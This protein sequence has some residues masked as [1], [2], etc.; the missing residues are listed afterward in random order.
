M[1]FLL[2][3]KLNSSCCWVLVLQLEVLLRSG[4]LLCD[5]R[6]LLSSFN[7]SELATISSYKGLRSS[8]DLIEKDFNTNM[9]KQIRGQPRKVLFPLSSRR[10]KL[11]QLQQLAQALKLPTSAS[12]DDL[13]VM[14]EEKLRAM[15]RNP[16]NTQVVMDLQ[17][18]GTE[19]LSL[20]DEEGQFLHV[21]SPVLS[22][23]GGSQSTP[24]ASPTHVL[25]CPEV[26]QGEE[27]EKEVQEALIADSAQAQGELTAPTI[28]N[29]EFTEL[30]AD[31]VV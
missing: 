27:I 2:I 5:S 9:S 30:K 19:N 22:P 6:G 15:D 4:Y 11:Y 21:T 12:S 25:E 3:I 14:V 24:R 16:V 20:Q 7:L 17:E 31:H 23:D 29:E 1:E 10:L 26:S 13:R 8:K 28:H 18:E